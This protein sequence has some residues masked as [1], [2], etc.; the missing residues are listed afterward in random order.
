MEAL[1]GE[2]HREEAH[3][4]MRG[5]GIVAAGSVRRI[6]SVDQV[7][8]FAPPR[9]NFKRPT[10]DHSSGLTACSSFRGAMRAR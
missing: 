6:G 7:R 10:N 4:G 8:H 2:A 1:A 9:H 3:S 5:G